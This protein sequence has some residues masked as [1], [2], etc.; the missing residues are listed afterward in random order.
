VARAFGYHST[1][2]APTDILPGSAMM[3]AAMDG[4][5]SYIVECGGKN[6]SFTDE[7]VSDAVERLHNAL[8]AL[9]MLDG[10]VT[11]YGKLNYFSNFDWV[12]AS[13]AGLFE[14]SVRCGDR[15]E[16][17]NSI[18]CYYDVYGNPAGEAEA[19]SAGIVLAIHPGPVMAV[20]ETLIHIGLDPREV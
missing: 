6:R 20:G 17:G 5:A 2:P 8:R 13:R 19:P 4:I 7:A 10:P 3:V 9:G 1:L 16:K 11:D 12:T 15:I 14:R 18:G